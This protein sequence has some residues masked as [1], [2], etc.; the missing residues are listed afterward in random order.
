MKSA[1]RP[2][3]S[4]LLGR[5]LTGLVGIVVIVR[6]P[7]LEHRLAFHALVSCAGSLSLGSL[8]SSE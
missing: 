3:R 5:P 6:N 2:L 4:P 8:K 1:M 7:L